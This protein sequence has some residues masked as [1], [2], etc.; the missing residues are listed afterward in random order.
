MRATISP[1]LLMTCFAPLLTLSQGTSNVV[2]L[3]YAKYQGNMS[4]PDTVAYLGLP[5]AEPPVEN[6]RFRA[7]VLLNTSRI[8]AETKGQIVDATMYPNFCIQGGDIC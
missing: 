1:L 7:P 5:F 2:D 3:G 4:F 6:L 8:Q